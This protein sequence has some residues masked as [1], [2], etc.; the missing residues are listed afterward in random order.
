MSN[1]FLYATGLFL[2]QRDKEKERGGGREREGESQRQTGL[3]AKGIWL[4]FPIGL[5][6][7]LE[8][9]SSAL[10]KESKIS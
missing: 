6:T 9:S 5:W 10:Q 4:P 1:S 8:G 2:T 3:W 7:N